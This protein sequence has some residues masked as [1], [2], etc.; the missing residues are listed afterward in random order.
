MPDGQPEGPLNPEFAAT[1]HGVG[2]PP[3]RYLQETRIAR[4]NA[5]N[6]EG[7]EIRGALHVIRPEDTVLEIGAGIGVVGS[8]IAKVCGPKRVLSF[9]ANPELIPEIRKLY[10]VN[11][12]EDRISVENAVLFSAPERPMSMPFYLHKS[13]LGSSLSHPGK[14]LRK[15]VTVPTRD[16]ESVC[17]GL[18][19]NVLVMDIEGG[20]LEILRHADMTRCRAVVLE[21]H[22][23]VYGVE[24]MRE[25]KAV[26][27]KA[28]LKPVEEVSNRTVWT[29][30]RDQGAVA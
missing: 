7:D 12:L 14:K 5:G 6:Y 29:C 11:G 13:Y 26:L 2:V 21:F 16:F 19:P 8:V 20:E 28:G 24:G 27:R 17:A 9:E 23:G 15:E 10:A 4:I 22:P 25:C 18:A 3:S 30:V 1:C